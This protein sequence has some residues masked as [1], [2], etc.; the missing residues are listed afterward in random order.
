M[1]RVKG[2]GKERWREMTREGTY[3]EVIDL[4]G[5]REVRE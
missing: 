5:K 3:T 1:E 4:E 2:G